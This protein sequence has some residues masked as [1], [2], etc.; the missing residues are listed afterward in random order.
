MGEAIVDG[1]T[2]HGF[3]PGLRN[4]GQRDR[5]LKDLNA[6]T[7]ITAEVPAKTVKIFEY[8]DY[9]DRKYK[10]KLTN[11]ATPYFCPI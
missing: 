8:I 9:I 4:K 10:F 1:R 2:V 11:E 7:V 6:L 3:L 5:A